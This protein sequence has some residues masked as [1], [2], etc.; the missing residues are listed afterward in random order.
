[1]PVYVLHFDPPYKHARHYI[2]FVK[3]KHRIRERICEHLSGQ[4]S[5]LIKAALAAQHQISL[6]HFWRSAPRTFET[7]LKRR[8]DTP[9]WC[10]SCKLHKRPIPSPHNKRK[11]HR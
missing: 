7:R 10:R 3:D 5:P 11:K 6:A 9:A 4:G 8:A 1:M 2:G